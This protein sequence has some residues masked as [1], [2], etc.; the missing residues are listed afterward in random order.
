[1]LDNINSFQSSGTFRTQVS[2][3]LR[4]YCTEN[5][6]QVFITTH[7]PTFLNIPKQKNIWL[8]S[9]KVT[10]SISQK[11]K[12][13]RGLIRAANTLDVRVSDV[14][15]SD[16][17]LFVEGRSDRI[18]LEKWFEIYGTPLSWPSVYI[19]EMNGKD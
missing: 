8:I 17:L 6:I 14:C 18:V 13:N 10:H 4:E 16:S 12:T 19:V 11:V 15:I 3:T 2:E 1:M 5:K 9:K 7:S